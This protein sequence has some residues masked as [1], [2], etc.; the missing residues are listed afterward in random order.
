MAHSNEWCYI[1]MSYVSSHSVQVLQWCSAKVTLGVPRMAHLNESVYL[2]ESCF[3]RIMFLHTLCRY[4]G[5][6]NVMHGTSEW[7]LMN[8]HESAY[9]NESCLHTPCA[10][11]RV[12]TCSASV[13]HVLQWESAH[14]CIRTVSLTWDATFLRMPH[15]YVT[16]SFIRDMAHSHVTWLIHVWHGSFKWC[17]KGNPCTAAFVL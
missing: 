4:S 15:S 1:W 17:C 3:Y 5:S 10:G 16:R 2:N 8:Q 14:S 6:A 11:A 13:R 9:V 7:V 12:D